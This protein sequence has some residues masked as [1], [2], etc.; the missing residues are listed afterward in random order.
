LKPA[1][2]KIKGGIFEVAEDGWICIDL[3]NSKRKIRISPDG[4]K[5]SFRLKINCLIYF[6]DSSREM[7]SL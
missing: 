4:I 3:E 6:L 1:K 7:Y 5:V 2:L